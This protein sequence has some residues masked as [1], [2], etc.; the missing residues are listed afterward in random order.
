MAPSRSALG[1]REVS[2]SG[3]ILHRVT[4]HS[5]VGSCTQR[6]HYSFIRIYTLN[7]IEDPY[8]AIV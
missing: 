2:R 5:F 1:G 7:D 3:S 6:G 8:I 4:R